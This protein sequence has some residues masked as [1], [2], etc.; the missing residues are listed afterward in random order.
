MAGPAPEIFVVDFAGRS[1]ESLEELPTVGA[2]IGSDEHERI[3][4]LLTRIESTIAMRTDQLANVRAADVSSY[5]RLAPTAVD[6]MPRVFV[7]IDGYQNFVSTYERIERGVWLDLVPKLIV[8]G[9]SVGVHFVLT[10]DRRSAVSHNV[11]GIIPQRIVLRMAG[12]DD[13]TNVGAP[14]KMLS[15]VSPEGRSV[16]DGFETQVAVPGGFLRADEQAAALGRLA[17]QLRRQR[18]GIDAPRI[19]TLP[20]HVS[21]NDLAIELPGSFAINGVDLEPKLFE[22]DSGGFLI[23]GPMKSGKTS[24]LMACAEA[25]RDLELDRPIFLLTGRPSMLDRHPV[26][27]HA[28]SGVEACSALLRQLIDELQ[29]SPQELPPAVFVDDFH[30][31][32]EGD[33]GKAISELLKVGRTFP[34]L[35]VATSDTFPAR[36]ASQYTPLGELRQFK[37]GLLLAPDTSQGDG[38]ILSA[39]LPNTSVKAWPPGR[40]YNVWPGVAELVQVGLPS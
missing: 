20:E 5:R 8:A 30:E 26:W 10:A 12:E 15:A 1:L 22:Q 11:Y 2:V 36:R 9:R 17:R 18:P 33:V 27:S 21:R 34:V 7:L 35:V 19:L 6:Q 16:F 37:T 29:E 3:T 14:A 13:Y 23:S 40:G 32:H 31:L 4:R 28:I 38:D 24:A 39:L 25:L